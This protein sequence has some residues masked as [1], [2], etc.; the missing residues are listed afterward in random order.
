MKLKFVYA[1]IQ[2]TL[3]QPSVTNDLPHHKHPEVTYEGV[4][5]TGMITLWIV[6][7]IMGLTSLAFM[8]MAYKTPVVSK[9]LATLAL[10]IPLTPS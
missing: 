3:S 9:H 5:H 6:F 8:W 7:A 1:L 2:L 4:E 10:H